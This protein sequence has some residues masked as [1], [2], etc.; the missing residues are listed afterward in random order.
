MFQLLRDHTSQP[1]WESS[2]YG[3]G[4]LIQHHRVWCWILDPGGAEWVLSCGPDLYPCTTS[5]GGHQS[6]GIHTVHMCFISYNH[7]PFVILHEVMCTYRVLWMI[8]RVI[9]NPYRQPHS[10]RM[11]GCTGNSL[12]NIKKGWK[13]GVLLGYWCILTCV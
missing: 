10:Y 12:W 3:A 4:C 11:L 6:L 5:M 9:C 8:L 13:V 7:V 1:L 2:P